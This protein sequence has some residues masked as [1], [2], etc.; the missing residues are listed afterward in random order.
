MHHQV[1]TQQPQEARLRDEHALRRHRQNADHYNQA[2]IFV[3]TDFG[4]LQLDLFPPDRP[5]LRCLHPGSSAINT[6][7]GQRDDLHKAFSTVGVI[8]VL[9]RRATSFNYS[10]IFQVRQV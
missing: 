3:V 7:D 8:I 2:A 9:K 1:S 5:D 6:Q 10:A 4:S